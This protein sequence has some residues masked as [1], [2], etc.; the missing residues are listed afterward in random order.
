MKN[1]EKQINQLT[2]STSEV[3]LRKSLGKEFT[4]AGVHPAA[5]EDV[6]ITATSG[7]EKFILGTDG[8]ATFVNRDGDPVFSKKGN[9]I[10]PGNF[11]KRLK[12]DKPYLFIQATG[13]GVDIS[14]D[15]VPTSDKKFSKW[16]PA[17]KDAYRREH[18]DNKFVDLVIAN[19]SKKKVA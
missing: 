14:I 16:T 4:A 6:L 1:L 15:G 17:E 11:A 10:T 18:G 2:R 7:K 19:G 8:A 12:I 5:M 9:V 13:S 3:S